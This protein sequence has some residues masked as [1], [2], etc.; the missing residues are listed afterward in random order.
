MLYG[1]MGGERERETQITA[2]DESINII[3]SPH[4]CFK[5]QGWRQRKYLDEGKKCSSI[6]VRHLEEMPVG[7]AGLFG[8][9]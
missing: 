1:P 7:L 4:C 5:K 6:T 9:F 3:K 8:F 2:E